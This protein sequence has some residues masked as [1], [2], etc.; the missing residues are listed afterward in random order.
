MTRIFF[1]LSVLLLV[2]CSKSLDIKLD[3]DVNVFLSSDSEQKIHLTVKDK[4]YVALNEWLN[5]HSASWQATSGVY[6][7]GVYLTSGRYGIQITEKQVIIYSSIHNDPQAIY[8][9]KLTKGE[10]S[11]IKNI[12]GIRYDN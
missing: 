11:G 4:E 9:Q 8:I 1:V 10:L 2:G 5:E 6:D 7:G 12:G 3:P